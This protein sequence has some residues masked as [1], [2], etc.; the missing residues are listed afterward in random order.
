[1]AGC[2]TT[3]ALAVV[4]YVRTAICHQQDLEKYPRGLPNFF[5]AIM[6]VAPQITFRFHRTGS[7]YMSPGRGLLG[8][9][10]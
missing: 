2:E 8:V 9:A 7:A 10:G 3:A 4:A 5:R 6:R 1:M